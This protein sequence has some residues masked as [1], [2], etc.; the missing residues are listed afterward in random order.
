[1]L[2][3]LDENMVPKNPILDPLDIF[4]YPGVWKW[5]GYIGNWL[6]FFVLGFMMVYMVS[7]EV[8]YKTMRQN[9]IT[10][11]SRTQFLLSKFYVLLVFATV[12][13]IYYAILGCLMGLLGDEEWSFSVVMDNDWAIP[14]F[15]LM[16][17]G[18]MSFAMLIGFAI[19]NSGLAVLTYLAYGIMLEVILRWMHSYGMRAFQ[20]KYDLDFASELHNYYPLNVME[21][22]QPIPLPSMLGEIVTIIPY[23]NAVYA[24]VGYTIVF[25]ALTYYIFHKRDL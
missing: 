11:L 21:D 8:T 22:L 23:S 14:R 10:G 3:L 17:V 25:L 1:M 9:V 20:E 4:R 12:A 2:V 5:L 6:V 16:C 15:F 7:I 18:Y 19:K 13:T 24:T